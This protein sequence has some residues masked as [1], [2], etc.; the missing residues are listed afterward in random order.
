VEQFSRQGLAFDVTDRGPVSG[1]TVLLLHGWPQDQRAFDAVVPLLTAAGLRVLTVDQ[2][3]YSPGALP[4]GRSAYAVSE[5]VADVVALLDSAQVGRVH[6]V[7]HDWGGTVAWAFAERHPTRLRSLTVLATP[8]HRAMAQAL[9]GRDQQRRS[10]Y[11]LAFQ[12]PV[13]PEALLRSRLRGVLERSGLPAPL[14][15]RYAARFREPGMAR[16]GLGWYRALGVLQAAK[17]WDRLRPKAFRTGSPGAGSPG[18]AS[19]Q[20]LIQ[21]PT[22]YVWGSLDEALG[23]EAA[24]LTQQFVAAD[25]RFVEVEAGHWLPE[26][27]PD[28]VAREVLRRVAETAPGGSVSDGAGQV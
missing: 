26:L 24:E 18:A 11:M 22:T 7:G 8:H 13:L 20:G 28:V 17:A 4:R 1:E 21:V 9:R 3:G 25:Y 16:G 6:L 27:C 14:A 15:Q 5:L 19:V 2:R 12:L 23:R 10:W